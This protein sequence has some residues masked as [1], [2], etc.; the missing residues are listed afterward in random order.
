MASSPRGGIH[1]E[2]LHDTLIEQ[3]DASPEL[4][5][6]IGL[7]RFTFEGKM[8]ILKNFED[9]RSFTNSVVLCAFT[10]AA[11]GPR[12][13][14]GEIREVVNAVTGYQIDRDEMLLIGERNYNLCR[15]FSVQQ[16]VSPADD[17]LPR[18][19]KE[20]T[21]PFA[22][23]EEQIPQDTLDQQMKEYFRLRGWDE[24]GVPTKEHLKKL[25]L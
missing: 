19:F 21:L 2:G 1:T 5:V 23:R 18:R 13:N 20:E 4:G 14:F 12:Y 11:T 16:G 8:P 6:G 15:L 3:D 10:T 17:D 7:S 24:K 9:A 25:G 22:D